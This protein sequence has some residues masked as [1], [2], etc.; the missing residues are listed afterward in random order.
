[1][2]EGSER[3]EATVL[4]CDLSGYTRWN[5]EED[6]EDIALVMETVR[7][8]ATR[9]IEE[10]GGIVNQF[11]GDEVMGLF[12]V[13]TSHEDDPRRALAA[14]L[15]FHDY[16]RSVKVL[17]AR[18]LQLHS[19]AETGLI[20]VRVRDLRAGVFEL[21]GEAVNTAARLRGVAGADEILCGPQLQRRVRDF[22][23]LEPRAPFSLYANAQ[24]IVP[25]RV[26]GPAD[27]SSWFEV[28]TLR[29][30]TRYVNREKELSTLWRWWERAEQGTGCL[31]NVLGDAG[32]GKTRFL[33]EFRARL[34]PGTAV[35]IG[36]C[37]AYRN[38][39]PYQPFIDALRGL[40]EANAVTRDESV[41]QLS[42]RWSL[43]AASRQAL[44]HLLTPDIDQAGMPAAAE[45]RSAIVEAIREVIA[46][47][48]AQRAV[49]VMLEDWHWA[50]EASRNALRLIASQLLQMRVLLVVNFRATQLTEVAQP[51]TTQRILLRPLTPIH[52]ESMAR[53]VLG[54]ER[55]PEGL[56][57]FVHERTLGNPFFVEEIC[58]S[59]LDTGACSAR[60]DAIELH[61]PLFQVRAPSTVQAIVRARVDRLPEELRELL[62][63]AAVIGQELPLDLLEALVNGE[64]L[65]SQLAP[66]SL[67]LLAMLEELEQHDMIH[68]ESLLPPSY[69]FKHAITR[70]VVYDSLPVRARRLQHVRLAREIE[71]RTPA[72][73]LERHFEALA[74]HYRLG[75]EW[76]KAI[77][78]ALRAGDKAW[79]AF[80]LEQ[81]GLQ[82]RFAIEGLMQP[83]TWDD[84]A[85]STHIEA[86]LSWARVGIYNPHP[87]QVIALRRSL[88]FAQ[89]LQDRTRAALCLNWLYWIEYGLGNHITSQAYA[90]KFLEEAENIGEPRYVAQARVNLAR[91]YM[92]AAE[93]QLGVPLIERGLELRSGADAARHSF[94]W[95]NLGM[96]VADQGDFERAHECLDRCRDIARGQQSL[97][98]PALILQAI[99]E[100][101][102]GRWHAALA[103]C[104]RAYDI[105]QRIQGAYILGM[106]RLISGFARFVVHGDPAELDETRAGIEF[107]D[108]QGIRLHMS[109]NWSLLASGLALAG[110]YDRAQLAA[111]HALV[112]RHMLDRQ[113]ECEALRVMAIVASTRDRQARAALAL[114]DEAV[115]AAQTKA[116][117]RE[118]VLCDLVLARV[119]RANGELARGDEAL[120]NAQLGARRLGMTL[121]HELDHGVRVREHEV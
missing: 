48:S 35:L 83:G 18:S 102:Q 3:R 24:P 89:E 69:R 53:S 82:Y 34:A 27:S 9:I 52:T 120:V 17:G 13:L 112:R 56:S 4:F 99:V 105:A 32:V 113:G 8:E 43:S 115:Q 11:V 107:L 37:S 28:A 7:A 61:Q 2:R 29:G 98:G 117:K 81:A 100:G 45:L 60:S 85:K 94:A 50:D 64:G 46:A 26:L 15:K 67:R 10:H 39:A 25:H 84:A 96:M 1:M 108:S 118:L 58:R 65:F 93:Y 54:G 79:R 91:C 12:G 5:E 71:S 92:V 76:P 30:L 40:I 73:E 19:G 66:S 14:A 88:D 49:F 119:L 110:D 62:R 21:T 121:L 97:I 75:N 114:V 47:L 111:E 23:R 103:T 68:R 59:L 77:E 41:T 106:S 86:S 104:A 44:T 95:T 101:W 22:Y 42:E 116:S 63:L 31:V 109:Y 87:D 36:R 55:L 90:E 6:P 72:D 80:A 20:Y 16:M 74:N 57:T 78:Y 33:H 38:V 51:Q 70:E